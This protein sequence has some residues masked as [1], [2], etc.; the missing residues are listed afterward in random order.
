MTNVFVTGGTGFLAGWVIRELLENGYHVTTS[1]RAMDKSKKVTSM[2]EAENVSTANLDFAVCD[3]GSADGWED[4]M[5]GC[6]YVIHTASPLG[7]DNMDDPS[8]I[9]IA[10][11][12]VE[13]VLQAAIRAG[14][15]KVVMTSSEAANYPDKKDPNP[16]IDETF[17]TDENN[18]WITKYMVSKLKDEQRAWELIGSQDKTQLTTILPGAILGPNMGGRHSST[19][20]IFTAILDG[21]PSPNVIYPVGDVRDLAHLHVLAMEL[22]AANGQRFIAESEEMTMPEMAK[23][24]KE[25]FPEYKIRT[26]V[27]PDFLISLMA[28]FNP[29]MKVLNTMIGLKYHR[30]NTKAR[31]LLGWNPRPA[32]ETVLDTVNYIVKNNLD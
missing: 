27:V 6:E 4:A 31:R 8:L 24:M 15:K 19:D 18:K 28:K 26:A 30:D 11:E 5:C 21:N 22:D 10:V 17:W 32:K 29:A 9:P 23:F 20:Q 2:L 25:A 3:L 7:G 12:G 13:H 16:K 1:V 14:V